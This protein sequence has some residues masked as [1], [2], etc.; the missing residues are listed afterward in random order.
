MLS[1]ALSRVWVSGGCLR[2]L[3]MPQNVAITRSLGALSSSAGSSSSLLRPSSSSSSS[4]SSLPRPT[5]S[6]LCSCGCG[7]H[8]IHTRGDR[9]LVEFLQEEIVAEKKTVQPN[10]PSHLGD[11]TVKASQAELTLSRT[12][13]DEKITLTLNVN[14]T[15]DT[16]DGQVAEMN[17]EQTEGVLKSRPSFEVDVAIGAKT[18]SFTCSYT[19]PGDLQGGGEEAGEDVFGIN[20]LTVY[21]GEWNEATY[22]VSGDILDGMMYDLLMNM[23]EE[24]GVTNEFAEQLSTLCSDYEHSLY[25]NLLQ[26]VQDFVKRK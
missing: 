6:M 18:L 20:E 11:F 22:C 25:V 5:S 26:G 7:I 16:D 24:R 8:G 1:R 10:L 4:S 3:K 19:A 17:A 14:H 15:V 9:E 13:H 23:L 2:A 21:E 12:F